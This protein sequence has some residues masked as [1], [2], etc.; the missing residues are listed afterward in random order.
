M[1]YYSE[2]KQELFGKRWAEV[3]EAL[4]EFKRRLEKL[5]FNPPNFWPEI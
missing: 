4:T 5:R 3:E 2:H 1:N